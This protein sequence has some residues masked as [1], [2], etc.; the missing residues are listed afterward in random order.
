MI[1]YDKQFT[2]AGKRKSK[3]FFCSHI[4]PEILTGRLESEEGKGHES[5]EDNE[6]EF[7]CRYNEPENK[8]KIDHFTVSVLSCLVIE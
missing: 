1:P 7:F 3:L 5:N 6:W 8:C 2:Q 4:L